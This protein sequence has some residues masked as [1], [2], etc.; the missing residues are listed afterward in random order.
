LHQCSLMR[1]AKD[2][3]FGGMCIWFWDECITGFIKWVWQYSFPFY[4]MEQ[5]KEG[6]Y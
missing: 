6:W 2:S 1:L 4:V 3:P 5:F